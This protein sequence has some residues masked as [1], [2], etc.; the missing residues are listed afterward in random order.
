[1]SFWNSEKLC[2]IQRDSHTLIYPF[3][4]GCVKHGAYELSL[5]EQ[6]LVTSDPTGKK[7]NLA[8]R[9]QL[10]IP[11]GQFGLLLTKETVSIPDYAIGF[12]SIRFSFKQ[13]GLVNVSGFHVDPGYNGRLEFAVYNAG[14]RNIVLSQG[15]RV[16]MMWFSDLSSATKDLYDGA[17]RNEI[18]SEDSM[19]IQGNLASPAA[20]K[21]QFDQLGS[22]HDQRLKALDDKLEQRLKALD[23][24]IGHRLSALDDKI[25]TW[26]GI[27]IALLIGI[28]LLLLRAF[29]Q[30]S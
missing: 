28:A 29:L 22:E 27:A 13:R 20:L 4:Q 24:S 30:S 19:M 6:A 18:T 2:D 1:M 8:D 5:G 12:I 15:D 25:S 17:G 16:F 23:D 11:P 3:E 9:E 7:Q 10:V 21:E 26:R 14:S